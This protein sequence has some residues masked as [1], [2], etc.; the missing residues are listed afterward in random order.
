MRR[1]G[2]AGL[3]SDREGPG[4]SSQGVTSS[5]GPV[6]IV[7]G[8]ADGEKCAV[9]VDEDD[10][11]FF[12]LNEVDEGLKSLVIGDAGT[13][14]SSQGATSSTGPVRINKPKDEVRDMTDCVSLEAFRDGSSQAVMGELAV[15]VRLLLGL[16][17]SVE[18]RIG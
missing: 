14:Y 5:T 3:N 10:L 17:F 18:V 13:G 9:G 2:D 1:T 6:L 4:D 7:R 15:E 12:W 16:D 8:A 11:R